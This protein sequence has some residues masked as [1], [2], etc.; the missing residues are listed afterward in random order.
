MPSTSAASRPLVRATLVL[1]LVAGCGGNK[2]IGNAAVQQQQ[3]G[4]AARSGDSIAVPAV[5]VDTATNR[6]AGVPSGQGGAGAALGVDTPIT[7]RMGSPARTR[8]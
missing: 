1:L 5:T 7:H 8:P 6:P 4:N 2:K 3:A